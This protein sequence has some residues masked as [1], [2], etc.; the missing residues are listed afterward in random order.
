LEALIEA[1]GRLDWIRQL[2]RKPGFVQYPDRFA[3]MGDNDGFSHVDGDKGGHHDVVLKSDSNE[4]D[5][6]LEKEGIG[7]LYI[8]GKKNAVSR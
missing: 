3:E 1:N 6:C 7:Q 2:E 4:S 8:I 5:E